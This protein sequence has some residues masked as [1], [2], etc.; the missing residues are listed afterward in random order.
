M[1]GP[2]GPGDPAMNESPSLE[3]DLFELPIDGELDLHTFSPRE[4]A[5]LLDDYIEACLARGIREIRIIHGKGRGDLRR[6]VHALLSR[7][8]CVSC[9]AL[10]SGPSGW[11][12]TCAALIP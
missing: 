9:F 6:R 11:G 12:A 10:D 4:V 8:P 2:E 5:P 3:E 7:H 1:S